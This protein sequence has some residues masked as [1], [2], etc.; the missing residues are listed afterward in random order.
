MQESEKKNGIILCVFFFQ[1]LPQEA[2]GEVHHG[3]Q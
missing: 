3:R 1:K 2:L